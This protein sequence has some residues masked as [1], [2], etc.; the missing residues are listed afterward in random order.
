MSN[1]L[2]D[3]TALDDAAEDYETSADEEESLTDDFDDGSEA[4]DEDTPEDD[5]DPEGDAEAAADTADV[6]DVEA[7]MAEWA[8]KQEEIANN[9]A[10][11]IAAALNGVCKVDPD[12]VEEAIEQ[13]LQDALDDMQQDFEDIKNAIDNLPELPSFPSPEGGVPDQ[14]TG[15]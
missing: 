15:Q 4:L 1:L 11:A 3:L 13:A 2:D 8:A 12:K 6:I 14:T 5:S 10:E 7:F 9:L